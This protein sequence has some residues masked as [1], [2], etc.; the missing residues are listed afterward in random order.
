MDG[1][2]HA[3]ATLTDF[4][5][6]QDKLQFDAPGW[7]G[8]QPAPTSSTAAAPNGG[9][10][11]ASQGRRRQLQRPVRDG[12]DRPGLRHR[13][14]RRGGGRRRGEGRLRDVLQQLGGRREPLVRGRADAAHSIARFSNLDLLADLKAAPLI[15]RL[16]LRR[17]RRRCKK[18][19]ALTGVAPKS[20]RVAEQPRH[21]PSSISSPIG[22]E[23]PCAFHSRTRPA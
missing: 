23:V 19:D 7:L 16:S 14:R 15:R 13:R 2:G 17:I 12:V 6:G 20:A 9:P 11:A 3:F 1:Q 10:A 18:S 4:N 5:A 8:R 22:V 21:R